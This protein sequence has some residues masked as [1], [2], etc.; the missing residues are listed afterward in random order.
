MT[1]D[2]LKL[3]DKIAVVTGAGNGIGFEICRQLTAAGASILLNDIDEV[4]ASKA[5]AKI[6]AAGGNCIAL[7]GDASCFEFI[8]QIV[9][10][11]VERFGHLDI[12]I[13]NA[14]V[15][16][17]NSFLDIQP[18]DLQRMLDLN[19][20]GSVF[21]A[22]SAAKQMIKQGNGGRILFMSSVT[23]HQAHEN[24]VCYGMTKAALQMLAKGLVGE[25]AQH[26]IT[27]NAI[28]PG[29][30]VTER[31]MELD[32]DFETKWKASTPTGHVCTT[33]DIANT[34]LFLVSPE[35]AQINGQ[36]LI[37]DGG[38]TSTSPTPDFTG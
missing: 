20:H 19:L 38:W 11:A 30:V 18:G 1:S 16:A 10:T 2:T 13:A 23:G 34:A 36:T 12:A 26:G 21:L 6:N 35:A 8:T 25:L 5:A 22:Q 9:D 27:T 37:V 24:L 15:T 33:A 17:F 3:Q 7:A 32:P 14:G 31:T 28:S 4:V 29:A